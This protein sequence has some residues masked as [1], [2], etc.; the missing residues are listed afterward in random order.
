MRKF[1]EPSSYWSEDDGRRAVEAWQ[2]SG[3]DATAFA[4]RHK[5]RRGRLLYWGKR[6]AGSASAPTLSFAPAAVVE[7]AQ[8][9]A[10]VI[11]AP[12]GIAVELAS[13]TPSQ[14]AAVVSALRSAP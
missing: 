11:R 9:V 14:I 13:A 10:A 12:G 7:R 6:L 2:Q 1:P 4:R 5:V 3:E 8:V